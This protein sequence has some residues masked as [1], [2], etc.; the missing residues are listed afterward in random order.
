M[1]PP[2]PVGLT[3]GPRKH[4]LSPITRGNGAALRQ[5]QVCVRAFEDHSSWIK[6]AGKLTLVVIPDF[7]DRERVFALAK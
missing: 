7:L 3:F 6:Q 2:L 4:E 5:R 1:T